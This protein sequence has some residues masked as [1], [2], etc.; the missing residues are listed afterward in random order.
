MRKAIRDVV[1][2]QPAQ[3]GRASGLRFV[4]KGRSLIFYSRSTKIVDRVTRC[5]NW[6]SRY[7]DFLESLPLNGLEI[8]RG[9]FRIGRYNVSAQSTTLP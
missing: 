1:L 8:F 5:D 6:I 2:G 9:R 4:Q 3:A 7:S